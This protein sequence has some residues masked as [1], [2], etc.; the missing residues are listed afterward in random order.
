MA[1]SGILGWLNIRHLDLQVT[2]PDEIYSGVETVITLHV[3]SLGSRLPSFLIRAHIL[4]ETVHFPIV[5]GGCASSLP[6]MITFHGRGEKVLEDCRVSSIF[7]VNFFVR[8]APCRVRDLFIVFPN[9]MRS[10]MP[11][12]V[13]KGGEG[14]AETTARGYE[15]DV[16]KIADYTGNEP[17][18]LIHWRLSAK[19]EHFKVKEMTALSAEP[20]ILDFTLVAGL[21]LEERLSRAAYLVNRLVREQRPVGMKI[22]GRDISPAATRAHRLLLLREL[23]LHDP[24]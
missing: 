7:P 12:S 24:N 3:R 13:G 2:F 8:F 14:V 1:V 10:Q 18:K 9:P 21:N 6:M 11:A 17:Q 5:E 16:A 4:G 19:H 22:G 20:I 15:G 23:A